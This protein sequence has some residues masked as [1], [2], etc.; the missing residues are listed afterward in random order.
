MPSTDFPNGKKITFPSANFY[1]LSDN[2]SEKGTVEMWVKLNFD[3][4]TDTQTHTLFKLQGPTLRVG[5][6][7]M[8][9]YISLEID[10]DTLTLWIEAGAGD[11]LNNDGDV[12]PAL[13]DEDDELTQVT[14]MSATWNIRSAA[15]PGPLVKG[16]WNTIAA[17]WNNNQADTNYDGTP[18]VRGF[19]AILYVNGQRVG[20]YQNLLTRPVIGGISADATFG[21]ADVFMDEIKY[22]QEVLGNV[23]PDNTA[24]Y[25]QG[26]Y[27]NRGTLTYTSPWRSIGDNV[28]L[29]SIAWS[30]SLPQS[31]I[32]TG[33]DI[34]S[35]VQIDDNMD[36][37][38]DQT[39][40]V[41]G[42]G[43]AAGANGDGNSIGLR[44]A[45]GMDGAQVRFIATFVPGTPVAAQNG[46]LRQ[47]PILDDVTLTILGDWE[48]VCW[49]DV[50]VAE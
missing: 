19:Q 18:D 45:A 21:P 1:T 2:R 15:A 22:R 35:R 8:E 30:E 40:A 5:T 33:A 25:P 34:T 13:F 43:T 16:Q 12:N 41:I 48:L 7:D 36:G 27:D 17:T 42:T 31:S 38:A 39:S 3:P 24:R 49:K 11:W 44:S 47:T 37:T 9:R 10:D 28:A 32:I 29:G 20:Q 23:N 26:R 14:G 46:L 4:A 6:T 50:P